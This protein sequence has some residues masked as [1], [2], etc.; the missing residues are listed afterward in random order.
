QVMRSDPLDALRAA[1]TA[2]ASALRNAT[3]RAVKPRLERSRRA[4]QGDYS[5]NAAMLLAPVLGAPPR[6][7]ASRLAGELSSALGGALVRVEVAG[8]GFLNLFMSDG[9]WREALASVVA[10]GGAFG[11]GGAGD[12]AERV[13]VEFVSA[14]PTG[15][16]VAA[17]GRHAA[18]GDGLARI[19]EHHGHSVSR[20]YYF[21]DAGSQI[22]RLGESVQARAGGSEVP[23]DGYQG[24]Y[25]NALAASVDGAASA[26]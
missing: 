9:W 3:D 8:P 20:E 23:E 15:P 19:L 16:L 12:A 21:N 13:L 17:S 24:E 7:I 2:S 1:V 25:V 22:R 26:D 18:Y 11:A 6:E 4:G 10:A 14:N 5:T